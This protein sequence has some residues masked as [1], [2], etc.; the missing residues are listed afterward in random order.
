VLPESRD[1]RDYRWPAPNAPAAICVIAFGSRWLFHPPGA[2]D[3]ALTVIGTGSLLFWAGDELLRGV[4]P[5]RRM[6]G[7]TVLGGVVTVLVRR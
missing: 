7:A 5:W 6:L 3:T 2:I 1:G 4:N